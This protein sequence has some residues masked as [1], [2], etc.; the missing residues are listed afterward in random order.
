MSTLR[1]LERDSFAGQ[2][3]EAQT[4]FLKGLI[5]VL[6]RFS[7]KVNRRKVLPALLEETRKAGLVPFLLPNIL[8]IGAK[9]EPVSL[10][11]SLLIP[12]RVVGLICDAGSYRMYLG[13]KFCRN[14]NLCLL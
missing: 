6:P 1:Y 7:D 2:T 4:G 9:M 3:L 14:S 5:S 11:L 13:K 10:F 8:F 12:L